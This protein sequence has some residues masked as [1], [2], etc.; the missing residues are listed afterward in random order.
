MNRGINDSK[1]LPPEYLEDIYEQIKRQE[2]TLKPTRAQSVKGNK[3]TGFQ[4]CH[5]VDVTDVSWLIADY[6]FSALS[7][8]QK[9]QEMN[10]IAVTAKAL[11]EAVSH[12]QS[13]FIS[14]KRYEHVRPMFQVSDKFRVLR[15]AL[16]KHDSVLQILQ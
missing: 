16:E 15:T 14:T 11:M 8:V 4:I 10:N 1:D 7:A 2:I 3:G 13:S 5:I 9:K 12:V 6:Y